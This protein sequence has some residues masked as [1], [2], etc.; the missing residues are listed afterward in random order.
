MKTSTIKLLQ[1]FV[2]KVCT[3]FTTPINRDFEKEG[4]QGYPQV[5]FN[6]FM[7]RI[8]SVDENGILLNQM[9]TSDPPLQSYFFHPHIISISQEKEYDPSNPED[10][11]VIERLRNQMKGQMK[12]FQEIQVEQSDSGSLD[13]ESLESMVNDLKQKFSN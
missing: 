9:G 13:P 3:V 4:P 1:R 8:E 12:D 2:G 6:Y 7:G 11:E 5:M 10:A